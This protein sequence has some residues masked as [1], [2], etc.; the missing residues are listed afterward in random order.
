VLARAAI[1]SGVSG[2]FMES[3]PDPAN[4]KSDGPNAWPMDKME[5]LLGT[6]VALDKVVKSEPF[7]EAEVG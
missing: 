6:L 1:A 3:H 2:L 7:A 4:A 5:A